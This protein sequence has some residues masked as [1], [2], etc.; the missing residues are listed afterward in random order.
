M[1]TPNYSLLLQ[2]LWTPPTTPI[3]E[4]S[5][6]NHHPPEPTEISEFIGEEILYPPIIINRNKYVLK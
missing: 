2:S 4:N 5:P 6:S 1:N 3:P